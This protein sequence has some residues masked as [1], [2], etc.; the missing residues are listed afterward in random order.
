MDKTIEESYVETLRKIAIRSG[1]GTRVVDELLEKCFEA[2][3]LLLSGSFEECLRVCGMAQ[4]VDVIS[5]SFKKQEANKKLRDFVTEQCKRVV[6]PLAMM[7]KSPK[8]SQE[9]MEE[10]L[11]ATQQRLSTR[12]RSRS[13]ERTTKKLD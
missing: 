13:R 4:S 6:V 5:H 8:E 11:E 2:V 10:I 9:A 12:E 3:R 7:K 1:A